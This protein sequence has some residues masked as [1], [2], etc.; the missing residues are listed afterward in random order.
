M[1]LNVRNL[2]IGAFLL[3]A[4]CLTVWLILFLKPSIGN[5]EKTLVVRFS[6]VNKI[7]VGTRVTF[8]GR[9]IGEVVEVAEI[10]NARDEPTDSLGRIFFYQLVIKY[11]SSISI[12]TCDE[13]L[14]QTSGLLG[15]KSIAIIPRKPTE[16][17]PCNLITASKPVYADSIDPLENTFYKLSELATEI[18]S[19]I[20][21]LMHWFDDTKTDLHSAISNFSKAMDKIDTAVAT[22]NQEQLIEEIKLSAQSFTATVHEIFDLLDEMDQNKVFEN[23]GTTMRNAASASQSIDQVAEKIAAG[24]GTLGKLLEGD[25]L[26]LQLTGIIT[27]V[28]TM[29]NDI[30]HYGILFHLNKGWQRLRS[31]KITEL[32]ALN[33]PEGFRS[34]FET[35]VDSIN[36]AMER[37]SMVIK[38]AETEPTKDE[39]FNSAPFRN[40]FAE[41]LR[42]VDNMSE[43]LRLYNE[44]LLDA[45]S[46]AP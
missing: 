9:P 15:E 39:I 30:N 37:L 22:L 34:Y 26:Y 20:G 42:E 23:I 19:A 45:M 38:K 28:N 21:N 14:V 7:G 31:Q 8:A 24:K 12:Y 2:L 25:D 18:Q 17:A 40:D 16:A 11:D 35:E 6:N 44:Q 5:G 27:K 4:I 33:T 10:A 29:M 41:L 36:T 1:I 46:G 3:G 43:M 32:N 13:I